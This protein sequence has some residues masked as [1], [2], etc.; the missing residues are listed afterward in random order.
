MTC[1][2]LSIKQQGTQKFCEWINIICDYAQ[3]DIITFLLKLTLLLRKTLH[4]WFK[5]K[6]RLYSPQTH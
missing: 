4:P 6:Y 3:K 2:M 1:V 5:A